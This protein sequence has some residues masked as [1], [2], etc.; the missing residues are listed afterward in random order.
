MI[1]NSFYVND[2]GKLYRSCG[3]C[4]TQYKRT[5]QINDVWAVSGS[6]LAGI[7]TNYGE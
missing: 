6:A 4:G 3:N 2:F 7:N 1:I 5:V